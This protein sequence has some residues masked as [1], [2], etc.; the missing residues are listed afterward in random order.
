MGYLLRA[1]YN[2][3]LTRYCKDDPCWSVDLKSKTIED[4]ISIGSFVE[5]LVLN[6]YVLVRK[7][8]CCTSGFANWT[9]RGLF[10]NHG[11]LYFTSTK[12][13]FSKMG[14]T[15]HTA[16]IHSE[17]SVEKNA[18]EIKEVIEEVYWGFKKRVLLLGHSKGGVDAAAALSMYWPELRD[19]VTG[20]LILLMDESQRIRAATISII[21]ISKEV[22]RMNLKMKENETKVVRTVVQRSGKRVKILITRTSEMN[23]YLPLGDWC[24]DTDEWK[25]R[26]DWVL[27]EVLEDLEIEWPIF[28]CLWKETVKEVVLDNLKLTMVELFSRLHKEGHQDLDIK[29][30]LN[31]IAKI[32]PSFFENLSPV[33]DDLDDE[34]DDIGPP[35]FL[36]TRT[37]SEDQ[38]YKDTELHEFDEY[39]PD[40]AIEPRLESRDENRSFWEKEERPRS[41]EEIKTHNGRICE[42]FKE[43]CFKYGLMNDGNEW[44]QAISEANVRASAGAKL[45]D[46][47]QFCYIGRLIVHYSYGNKTEKS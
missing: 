13:N 32:K 28:G 46:L 6:Q 38:I 45:R 47:L 27:L 30:I 22:R 35:G 39:V 17:A 16:K 18:R 24:L 41:F 29:K 5:V 11:P 43:A 20:V 26:V 34:D 21:N 4:I 23:Q 7:I 15:C 25:Y 8:F 3:S 33:E 42:A 1:C 40:L 19:K 12:A 44:T 10:S 37:V 2:I 14:L 36:K 9:F 31:S